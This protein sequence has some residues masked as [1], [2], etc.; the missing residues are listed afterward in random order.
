MITCTMF[1]SGNSAQENYVEEVFIE[2]RTEKTTITEDSNTNSTPHGSL[3]PETPSTNGKY[4][5]TGNITSKFVFQ[6]V[7]FFGCKHLFSS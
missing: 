6:L 4:A 5:Q 1:L 2:H 7:F 3:S